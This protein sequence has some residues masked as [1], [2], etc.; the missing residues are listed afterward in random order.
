MG[1]YIGHMRK[2]CRLSALLTIID[3][4]PRHTTKTP[5]SLSLSLSYYLS[6]CLGV[7]M[8]EEAVVVSTMVTGWTA[9]IWRGQAGHRKTP[10]SALANPLH[11]TE[12]KSIPS[13]HR[14]ISPSLSPLFLVFFSSLLSTHTQTLYK[15]LLLG[16]S[17]LSLHSSPYLMCSVLK[18]TWLTLWSK[19]VFKCCMH[20]FFSLIKSDEYKHLRCRIQVHSW[21]YNFCFLHSCFDVY[22]LVLNETH[23]NLVSMWLSALEVIC[24]VMATC[25]QTKKRGN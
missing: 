25:S 13:Y 17:L 18:A 1:L 19:C 2:C 11:P 24:V 4:S 5:F 7:L 14:H 3:Y 10:L 15:M 9:G 8:R 23:A 22:S 20:E 21:A 16:C 12:R 6:L